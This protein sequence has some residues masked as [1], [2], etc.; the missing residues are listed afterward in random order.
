M[1]SK[2][3]VNI[4]DR[5]KCKYILVRIINTEIFLGL[6]K[7]AVIYQNK[8]IKGNILSCAHYGPY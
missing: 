5:I 4:S 8:I 7:F 2:R 6:L 1:Y 3:F